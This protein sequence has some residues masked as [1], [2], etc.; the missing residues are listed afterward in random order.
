MLQSVKTREVAFQSVLMGSWYATK[1][2]RLL[3]DN[4]H[5]DAAK[6]KKLFY[7]ANALAA[8]AKV[9]NARFVFA[10]FVLGFVGELA[11]LFDFFAATQTR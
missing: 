5:K 11:F 9:N 4:W 3:I 10:I 6:N 2:L 1:R 8:R 7:S